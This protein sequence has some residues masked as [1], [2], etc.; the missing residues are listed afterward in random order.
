MGHFCSQTKL[1]K[2]R[3]QLFFVPVVDCLM[4]K[5]RLK[6]PDS[7]HIGMAISPKEEPPATVS[8]LILTAS[9]EGVC[10]IYIMQ[11]RYIIKT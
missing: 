3:K 8:E 1:I 4:K 7:S 9:Q 5:A 10:V 11:N 2:T 6:A